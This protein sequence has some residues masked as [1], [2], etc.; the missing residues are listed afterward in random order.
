[1][2]HNR[3]YIGAIK[4]NTLYAKLIR[5]FQW[6]NPYTHTFYIL[7][8]QEDEQDPIIIEALDGK[9]SEHKLST[10]HDTNLTYSIYYVSATPEQQLIYYNFMKSK[11]DTPYDKLG[12]IDFILRT[13]TL[14]SDLKSFCSEIL[15]NAF[16]KAN[17]KLFNTFKAN[18]I[19]P[20]LLLQP[21]QVKHYRTSTVTKE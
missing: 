3:I 5:W 2:N 6:G 14:Q 16:L 8:S 11:L 13:G 12:V 1:M 7:P 21:T 9:V 18:Y 4:S 17:I 10:T 20:S 19:F 15:Y